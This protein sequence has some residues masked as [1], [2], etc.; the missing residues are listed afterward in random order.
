MRT[1]TTAI[2]L[3]CLGLGLVAGCPSDDTDDGAADSGSTANTSTPAT[4][5]GSTS[6]PATDGSTSTPATT[7]ATDDSTGGDS[8]GPAGPPFGG[9]E[10]V[11][12]AEQLWMD[13]QGWDAWMPLGPGGV[14][15]SAAPHSDF[16]RMFL[17]DVAAGDP[18]YPDG[19]ILL[20]ENLAD[21][22]GNT[23]D[24][25]TVM[26]KID[27]YEP[28]AAD[29]FWAKYLPDGTLDTNPDGVP[30]AGR[31]GLGGEMGCIPCHSG[32]DGGDYVFSN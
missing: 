12:L 1:N 25:V 26:W 22:M 31:V 29:W 27:G 32:A 6:T 7:S 28:S 19:S 2:F 11:M 18:A 15:P 20:K 8:T 17:N 4:D 14:V 5:D 23:L 21:D 10:D 24:A 30:L 9:E 16:A 3:A 13:I